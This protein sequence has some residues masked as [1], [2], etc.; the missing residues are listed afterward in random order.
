[1][2]LMGLCEKKMILQILHVNRAKDVR[3]IKFRIIKEL[4]LKSL[5]KVLVLCLLHIPSIINFEVIEYMLSMVTFV[6][7]IG[8]VL[9]VVVEVKHKYCFISQT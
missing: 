3:A 8:K 1:M 7:S 4:F 5:S 6:H 2:Y 9:S